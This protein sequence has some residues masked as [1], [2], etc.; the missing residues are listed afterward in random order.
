MQARF[1]ASQ[2]VAIA[3]PDE[4][5]PIQHYL[6]QP[7]R[8][9]YALFDPSRIE[10]LSNECFR[11]KMRPLTFIM[12]NVQPIVDIRVKTAADGT[13]TVQSTGCEI[14]GIESFNQHFTL[15]LVGKLYPCQNHGQ[16]QLAGKAD[17]EVQVELPLLLRFTPK[18]LIE[19]TGNGL[20]K[21]IL[22]TIK[23][24]LMHQLLNDYRIWSRTGADLQTT[25]LPQGLSVNPPTV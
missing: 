9:V 10:P 3:V 4:P 16:L 2:S 7:H 6:R 13:V 23:Q 25:T 5:I 20:L 8:L 12:L 14:R 24:R 15:D 17:L 22:L 19:A 21:S 11:L 1:V 18:P